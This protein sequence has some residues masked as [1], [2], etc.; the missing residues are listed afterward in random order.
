EFLQPEQLQRLQQIVWQRQGVWAL[1]TPQMADQLAL[2]ASQRSAVFTLQEAA[3]RRHGNR[4]RS[5]GP[6]LE[7]Q[8]NGLLT[9]QQRQV[10][11]EL[12]GPPYDS[13]RARR[14]WGPAPARTPATR[15]PQ[16]PKPAPAR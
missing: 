6:S 7:E 4:E 1:G 5:E 13:G 16:T 8:I 12:L 3:L 11:K 15:P 10:W 2:T 9:P 14:S